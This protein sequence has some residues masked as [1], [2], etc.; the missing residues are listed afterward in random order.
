MATNRARRWGSRSSRTRTSTRSR[1]LTRSRS[2]GSSGSLGGTR[3]VSGYQSVCNGFDKKIASYRCLASQAK[4][5]ARC[6]RPSPATLNS[7][8]RWIEKGAV[9]QKVSPTQ[10][11]RWAGSASTTRTFKSAT[12]AKTVLQKRF[13][14]G[15]IKAVTCDKS[16]GFLVATPVTWKGRSFS[17]PR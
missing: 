10:I 3:V 15:C 5:P 17:F 12:S 4:G 16:G 8:S 1:T 2:T 11:K 6:P 14:R 9:I 13:G 7:F